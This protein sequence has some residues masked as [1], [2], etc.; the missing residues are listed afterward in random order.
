MIR[1]IGFAGAMVVLAATGARAQMLTPFLY[2]DQARQHC[3]A[4][5]VVWLDFNKRKYYLSSQKL[6]GSGLHGSFVCLQEARRNL[7][8]RSPLGLR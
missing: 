7:Y 3:P 8:R 4:D 2:E 1:P 5:T 6:Y